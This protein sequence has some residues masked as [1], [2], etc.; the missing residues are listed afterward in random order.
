MRTPGAGE[1]PLS[2]FHARFYALIN[3]WT[4]GGENIV[5]HLAGVESNTVSTSKK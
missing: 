1:L 2:E 3:Q 5:E 4:D